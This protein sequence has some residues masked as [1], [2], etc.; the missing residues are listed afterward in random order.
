MFEGASYLLFENA[1]K[2]RNNMTGAEMMLW[3]HI[4]EGINGFKVRRQHPIGLYVADFYCHKARLII[5]LDGSIHNL[6]DIQIQDKDRQK[7][8]ERWGYHV[9]R[10]TNKEIQE[11]ID[12]VIDEIRKTINTIINSQKQNASSNEGV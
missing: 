7:D 11:G 1:K 12:R 6:K 3:M 9:I 2:L 8:L 5:E 10:F 4:R